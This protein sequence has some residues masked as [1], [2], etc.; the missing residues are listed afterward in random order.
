MRKQMIGTEQAKTS[1]D[2]AGWLDLER[3][4]RVELSS[5]DPHYPI[6]TALTAAPGA[7]W[8]AAEAGSQTIRLLFDEPQ[9][10]RRIRLVFREHEHPRTQ[11]FVI[12]WSADAGRSVNEL[13]RQQYNFS[14][15]GTTEEIED[16]EVDLPGVVRI[17]LQIIP[18]VGG[19]PARASLAEL[20][21]G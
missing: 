3:L 17:E 19:G 15:S 10:L 7:G 2:A 21:L 18:D 16:Y 12:R 8:R 14:P 13:L 20:R 4:A 11:E 6:E 1:P 5:E 9:H